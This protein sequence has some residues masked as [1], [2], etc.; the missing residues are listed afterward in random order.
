MGNNLV[1]RYSEEVNYVDCSLSKN[2]D[3][4]ILPL[5]YYYFICAWQVVSAQLGTH[6]ILW[7]ENIF[8]NSEFL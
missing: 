2:N 5:C 8:L 4:V 3:C 7:V 6:I 1:L